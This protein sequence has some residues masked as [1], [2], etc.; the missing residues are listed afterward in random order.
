M[1]EQAR[2]E[3]GPDFAEVYVKCPLET[4]MSRDPKG[5]YKKVREG[6]IKNF[7][8]V[9]HVYEAPESPDLVLDTDK[10]SKEECELMVFDFLKKKYGNEFLGD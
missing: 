7:T 8:G 3:L 5:L 4:C 2:E 1:R 9:S 6:Q 10:H